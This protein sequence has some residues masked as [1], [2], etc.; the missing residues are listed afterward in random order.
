[1]DKYYS[2]L[3]RGMLSM[4]QVEI[5]KAQ[6]YLIDAKANDY[7]H[8]R[9]ARLLRLARALQD[10]IHRFALEESETWQP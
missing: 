9:T 1:M 4:V 8:A 2:D 6:D 7:L 3:A 10:D 5:G